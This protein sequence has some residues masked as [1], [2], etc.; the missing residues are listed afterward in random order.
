M[1]PKIKEFLAS[2]NL[3]EVSDSR[4][5]QLQPFVDFL[6]ENLS[7][8]EQINLNF[9]CTHNSRRS[10]FSQIWAQTIA[11]FLGFNKLQCYSGGTEA[12]AVYTSVLDVF[13]DSGFSVEKLSD[14]QNSVS[15][16]KF[17]SDASPIICFSKAFDHSFN[18]ENN[19][20]AVMTCA[21]AN[22]ACPFVPGAEAR[23]GFSFEDP[24]VYDGFAE[25]FEKYREKSKEIATD[26]MYVFTK[27][28]ELSK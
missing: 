28:K 12:T 11:E 14:N 5:N 17:A 10:H 16:L 4:K 2:L 26:L 18:P 22:E 27:A 25:E 6:T 1:Y 9:I 3:D 23:I 21:Q 8:K 7:N 13:Q 15:Y 24:K 20:V 19:F